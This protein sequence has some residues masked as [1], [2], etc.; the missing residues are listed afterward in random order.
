MASKAKSDVK[1]L[2]GQDGARFLLI[3][4]LHNDPSYVLS[5]SKAENK[6][7]D[8]VKRVRSFA[9][10]N[11]PHSTCFSSLS[12]LDKPSIRRRRHLR[13]PERCR[14]QNSNAEDPPRARRKGR[15]HAEN[16]RY[17]FFF[18]LFPIYMRIYAHILSGK[19]TFFVT[20]QGNVDALPEQKVKDLAEE[21]EALNERNK[22][23]AAEIKTVLAGTF[24]CA[25]LAYARRRRNGAHI[26]T[27]LL[28][29]VGGMF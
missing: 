20:N 10:T 7:F 28:N 5:R 12:L 11:A 29:R 6:V 14:P 26:Y 17:C 1:V 4:S 18:S 25:P 3:R 15:G 2:K 22:A 23:L 9:V 27:V 21:T 8:Y 19:A 24:A 16:L 13:Q